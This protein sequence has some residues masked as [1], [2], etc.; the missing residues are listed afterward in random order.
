MKL[1]MIITLGS[2][3]YDTDLPSSLGGKK[4]CPQVLK[5]DLN[6]TRVFFPWVIIL[7]WSILNRL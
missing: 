4:C 2:F 1:K 6:V 5:E 7:R 3:P